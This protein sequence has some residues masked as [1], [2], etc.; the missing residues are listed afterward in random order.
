MS[1]MYTDTYALG[2][3]VMVVGLSAP[4]VFVPPAGCNGGFFKINSGSGTLAIGSGLSQAFGSTMY[5]VGATEIVSFTG[6]AQFFLYAASATMT[7][8]VGL[9][10]SR[11]A[12]LFP[13]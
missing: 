8:S 9:S 1:S 6:P 7:V 13:A 11:G 2:S 12:S 3:T 5:P 4:A 10:F